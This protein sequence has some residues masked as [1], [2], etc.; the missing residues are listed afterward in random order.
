MA[1]LRGARVG[2]NI[3]EMEEK[4]TSLDTEC[5]LI[6]LCCALIKCDRFAKAAIVKL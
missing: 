2:D 6:Y 5:Y 4:A 3:T 1:D